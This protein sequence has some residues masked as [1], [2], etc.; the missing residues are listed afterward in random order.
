M[1]V[2][3]VLIMALAG[4]LTPV[5]AQ[6]DIEREELAV[7]ALEALMSAPA[8]R[9]LPLVQKVLASNHSDRVKSRALFILSQINLP[10]AQAELVEFAVNT[11]SALQA[12]AIRMIGIGGN[13]DALQALEGIY[14]AGNA[15]TKQEV[16][17]AYLIAD[18]KQ[19]VYRLATNATNDEEFDQ[20][21]QMLG[22][23]GA[24]DELRQLGDRG[25][26]SESLVRAH[27]M[28]GDLE[29]LQQLIK[30]DAVASDPELQIEVIN[31]FG[32]IGGAQANQVLV[33]TYRNTENQDVKKAVLQG[34]IISG[35]EQGLLE[36]YRE[37]QN[38]DE[39]RRLLRTL[40]IIGGDAA[41][42]AIDAALQG[43]QP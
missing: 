12:E 23:M 32:I 39:K 36:L 40:G 38:T 33:D 11:D 25:N 30:T 16:L 7:T 9:A 29:G 4:I 15:E 13:A 24:V 27:V 1:R 35:H 22:V 18:D 34:M 19:A 2:M 6:T 41:L 17:Q 3:L 10:E 31:G 20:A 26:M 42:E 28:S 8:D 43:N 5:Q 37:A 21:I 14:A